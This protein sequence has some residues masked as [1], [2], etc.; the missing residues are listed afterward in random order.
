LKRS[1]FHVGIQFIDLPPAEVKKI[2]SMREYFTSAHVRA[3]IETRKRQRADSDKLNT[4][5]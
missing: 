5:K 1:D 4:P 2:G 3:M